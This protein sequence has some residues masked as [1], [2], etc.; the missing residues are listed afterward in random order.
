MPADHDFLSDVAKVL[1]SYDQYLADKGKP[2]QAQE[3]TGYW[4]FQANPTRYDLASALAQRKELDWLALQ[5]ANEMH[6]GDRVFMWEA[7]ANAGVVGTG[8]IISPADEAPFPD[9]ELVF[10]RDPDKFSGI[11]RRVRLS[12]DRS[13]VPRL[14]GPSSRPILPARARH[15]PCAKNDELSASN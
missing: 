8:T 2:A 1:E 13:V 15:R 7:G 4:I 6:V 10:S 5:R 3:R 11:H 12:I 9:D 14:A